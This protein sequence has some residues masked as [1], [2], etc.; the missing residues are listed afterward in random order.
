M[1][2]ELAVAKKLKNVSGVGTVMKRRKGKE[3]G[4]SDNGIFTAT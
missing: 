1:T 2:I 3:T 4:L